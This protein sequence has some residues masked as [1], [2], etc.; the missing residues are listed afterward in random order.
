MIGLVLALMLN[1]AP[2][3]HCVAS[4]ARSERYG[5]E[6]VVCWY[7]ERASCAEGQPE[8][9]QSAPGVSCE[10]LVVNLGPWNPIPFDYVPDRGY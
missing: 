2:P 4:C 3:R 10:P 8:C 5:R 9:P 7:E 6:V 1:G